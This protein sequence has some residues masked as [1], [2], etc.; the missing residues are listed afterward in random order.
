MPYRTEL[1]RP[2][3]KGKQKPQL[4]IYGSYSRYYCSLLF[5]H[6]DYLFVRCLFCLNMRYTSY[7]IVQCIVDYMRWEWCECISGTFRCSL[8]FKIFCHSS[9]LSRHRMQAHFK[10]YT[11]TLCNKE[12]TSK[13][14]LIHALV[15]TECDVKKF[16]GSCLRPD[17]NILRGGE[18][19]SVAS[20][21]RYKLATRALLSL[22]SIY[23]KTCFGAFRQRKP[24]SSAL[25]TPMCRS[26][27]CCCPRISLVNEQL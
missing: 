18:S 17:N 14:Q 16:V 21:F 24:D 8:C 1:K 22:L 2:D 15:T 6:N 4:S 12:I 10:S 5:I 7:E 27:P 9:S 11:C 23:P 13:S 26:S 25:D 20:I 19:A 3:L